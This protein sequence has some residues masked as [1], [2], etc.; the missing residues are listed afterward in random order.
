MCQ[1]PS[2]PSCDTKNQKEREKREKTTL[3]KLPAARHAPLRRLI[4]EAL[5][6][7]IRSLEVGLK[8]PT[9]GKTLEEKA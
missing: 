7:I 2:S 8:L 4:F 3:I 5:N 1:I 9:E 6:V